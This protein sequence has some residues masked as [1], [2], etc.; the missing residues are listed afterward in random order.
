MNAHHADRPT[1]RPTA[2][3]AA[4]APRLALH[5]NLRSF[6]LADSFPPRTPCKSTSGNCGGNG[7]SFRIFFSLRNTRSTR[8]Q[9]DRSSSPAL[10]P[11]RDFARHCNYLAVLHLLLPPPRHDGAMLSA[12]LSSPLHC[13]SER[14]GEGAR[15]TNDG[16][17]PKTTSSAQSVSQS[18]LLIVISVPSLNGLCYTV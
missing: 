11:A 10:N 7:S 15:R 16:H 5:A 4:A 18:V 3:T 13:A 17:R 8:A 1:D 2:P 6:L 14:A 12:T 9:R